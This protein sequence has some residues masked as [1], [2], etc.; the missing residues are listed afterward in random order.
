[1]SRKSNTQHFYISRLKLWGLW[2]LDLQSG[3]RKHNGLG[4]VG[5]HANCSR[6]IA[7]YMDIFDIISKYNNTVVSSHYVDKDKVNCLYVFN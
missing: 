4:L 7:Q 3:N 5:L 6:H 1:M 2:P